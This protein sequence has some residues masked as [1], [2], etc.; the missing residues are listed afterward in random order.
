MSEELLQDHACGVD[1]RHSSYCFFGN[2][3]KP[4]YSEFVSQSVSSQDSP[5]AC[6]KVSSRRG[7]PAC[8]QLLVV[9]GISRCPGGCHF[10][11]FLPP[12]QQEY[13]G[14]KTTVVRWGGEMSECVGRDLRL[15]MGNIFSRHIAGILI[16]QIK[17]AFTGLRFPHWWIFG[18]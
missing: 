6:G 8:R 3:L 9:W 4:A 12:A 15:S 13:S 1:P 17:A 5:S 14:V 16:T 11:S 10:T 18:L 2:H 7:E